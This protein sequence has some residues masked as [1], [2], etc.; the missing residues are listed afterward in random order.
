MLRI[1]AMIAFLVPILGACH[2]PAARSS[3]PARGPESAASRKPAADPFTL[4]LSSGG[5][6]AG[7]WQGCTFD[8]AGKATAWTRSPSGPRADRW[9]RPADPDSLRAFA[10]ELEASLGTKLEQTGNM[11]WRLEYASPRGEYQWSFP[12][13]GPAS[14]APEP[15]NTLYP[16]IEAYCRGLNPGP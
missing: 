5:G 7:T 4:T 10:R 13:A 2:G 16:R 9:T 11:T 3:A 8:S 15:F 14:G 6:F 1:G 12:G